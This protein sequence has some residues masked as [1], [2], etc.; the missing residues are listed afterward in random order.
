M[1]MILSGKVILITRA[2][3]QADGFADLIKQY[4]GTPM[5]FPAIEITPPASWNACDRAIENLYMYD[6]IVFTSTN[7]V[8]FF[9]LRMTERN[10]PAESIASK[11]I[12]A[13]GEKT[14]HAVEQFGVQVIKVPEKYTA[15]D[16]ANIIKQENLQGK[17]FLFPKGNLAKDTLPSLLRFL[18]AGVDEVEFYQTI[19]PR[20]ENVNAVSDMLMNGEINVVTFTSPS[21]VKSFFNLI[22]KSNLSRR[23]II[24]AIGPSTASAVEEFKLDVDIQPRQST[25]EKFAEAIA[26]YFQPEIQNSKVSY[27]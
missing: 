4:G 16:L 8:D 27:D 13:V 6:G 9:S 21:T 23:T 17:T 12:F 22:S 19:Q 18:G 2:A 5:I 26:N 20:P 24:A 14:R 7:G 15:F 25:I 11:M 3:H 10:I 1:A